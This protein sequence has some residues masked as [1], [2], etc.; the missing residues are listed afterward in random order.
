MTVELLDLDHLG[1]A[2][3]IGVYLL[4][5][6]E[7]ALIDC[8]PASCASTLVEKLAACGLALQD[9][10]HVVLT[11]IHP[12][13]AGAAGLLVRLNPALRVH[14]HELGAPHLA[15]PARLEASARQ[16]YGADYD[17]LFG[18][19]EP[20]P[21]SNLHVLGDRVLELAAFPTPGHARHHVS[22]LGSDGACYAGDA[23]GA[24]VPP[25]GALYPAAAPP[26]IDLDGW[27]RSLDAI[28]ARGP[29]VLRLPHFGEI[30]EPGAHVAAMRDRLRRFAGWIAAGMSTAEFVEAAEAEIQRAGG[31]TGYVSTSFPSFALTYEGL[32]RCLDKRQHAHART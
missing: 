11:H 26:G 16:L 7:P 9:L 25:G 8:G 15:D 10:R 5:G 22:F 18:P 21:A 4:T 19:I 23:T 31:D 30:A 27:E 32:K 1:R 3:V 20:C 17:R 14:V 6:P 24:L 12:D 28:L 29:S 2:R 13:H